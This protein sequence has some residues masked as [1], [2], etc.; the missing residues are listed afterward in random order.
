MRDA[1]L[2]DRLEDECWIDTPQA[3]VGA[4]VRRHCPREAPS[5]AMEHRQ[6][7]QVHRVPRHAPLENVADAVQIR[8][9]VVI[10]D[11]LRVSGRPRRVVQR[12][13]LPFVRRPLPGIVRVAEVDKRLVIQLA[14]PLTR[15]R[16]LRVVDVDHQ[17]LVFELGQRPAHR[18]RKLAVCYHH[19]SA[20]MPEHESDRLRVQPRV[21]RIQHRARHGHAEM[22]FV[23]L[24]RIGRHQSHRVSQPNAAPG[25]RRGQA[26]RPSIRFRPGEAAP[27]VYDGGPL[28]VDVGAPLD[29]Q[30]RG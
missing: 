2:L 6:R 20:A 27:A 3:D 24:R 15:P 23:H 4:R 30:E 8:A 29:E 21:Q 10:N 26:A 1:V 13:R 16:V 7:P 25:Q 22:G 11:T 28:R 14:E 5:V 9:S 19:S 18:R 17:R 12:Y